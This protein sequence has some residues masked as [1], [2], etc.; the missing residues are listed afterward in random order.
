MCKVGTVGSFLLVRVKSSPGRRPTSLQS[1]VKMR[2]AGRTDECRRRVGSPRTA[3]S[4]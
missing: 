4:N 2:V 1:I 3:M